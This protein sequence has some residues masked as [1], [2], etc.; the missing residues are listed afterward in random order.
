MRFAGNEEGS[1]KDQFGIR[2]MPVGEISACMIIFSTNI[3]NITVLLPQSHHFSHQLCIEILASPPPRLQKHVDTHAHAFP[4]SPDQRHQSRC[5]NFTCALSWRL[6]GINPT[7]HCST[8]SKLSKSSSWVNL[9][10]V[11]MRQVLRSMRRQSQIKVP[12]SSCLLA[13]S[14]FGVISNHGFFHTDI[15]G[16]FPHS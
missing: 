6:C 7:T 9:R 8:G 4:Q 1:W 2:S 12:K 14:F 10:A 3:T 11:R 13:C 5:A 15:L 16:L